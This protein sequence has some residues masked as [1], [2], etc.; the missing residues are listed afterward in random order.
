MNTE[1]LFSSKTAE[2][3]TPQDFFDELNREFHF[4]LDP[5]ADAQNH[6]CARYYTKEDDGLRQDWSGETVFC[7]PPYGREIEAWVRKCFL[8]VYTGTCRCAVLLLPAR[9][10]TKWF[11]AYVYH[12][13]E[14][15]FIKGRLKFGG[16]KY[17]APFPAMVIIFR[18]YREDQKKN[19]EGT[20]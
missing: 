7:N 9:T 15:R 17:N 5:C 13:A 12:K 6:K 10:D 2:W 1:V 20:K 16:A 11:H 8:E 19:K 3:E 18:N 14:V 4:S